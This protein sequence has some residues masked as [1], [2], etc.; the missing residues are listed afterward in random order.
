MLNDQL[1]DAH[2]NLQNQSILL[3]YFHNPN[4]TNRPRHKEQDK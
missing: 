1:A 4:Y 3:L 2:S